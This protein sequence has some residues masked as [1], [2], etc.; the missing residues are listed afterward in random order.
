MTARRQK[1]YTRFDRKFI[2]ATENFDLRDRATPV[3][4]LQRRRDIG[5]IFRDH[6]WNA[7]CASP[8]RG[9]KILFNLRAFWSTLKLNKIKSTVKLVRTI[10]A[11]SRQDR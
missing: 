3:D 9:R 10:Q 7:E 4:M 2:K 1:G 5:K 6:F 8:L 11:L